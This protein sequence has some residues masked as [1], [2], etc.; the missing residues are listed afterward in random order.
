M[1]VLIDSMIHSHITSTIRRIRRRD[2]CRRNDQITIE[3]LEEMNPKE[4]CF[5]QDQENQRMLAFVL[6]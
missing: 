3:Q 5:R 1:I 2:C 4:L 6:K